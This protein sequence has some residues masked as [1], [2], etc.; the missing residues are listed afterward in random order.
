LSEVPNEARTWST[1][2][3]SGIETFTAS[4]CGVLEFV[5]LGVVV[6]V[7]VAVSGVVVVVTVA[8]A[9]AGVAVVVT[10]AVA[11]S[12][13][14]VV[15]TV[16]VAVAVAVSGVVVVVTV[17]V[18]VAVSGVVVVVT[19]AGFKMAPDPVSHTRPSE[20]VATP[21]L[22]FVCTVAVSDVPLLISNSLPLYVTFSPCQPDTFPVGE[23]VVWKI[24]RLP[25]GHPIYS[26]GIFPPFPN[27]SALVATITPHTLPLG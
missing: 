2:T 27:G 4:V 6:V 15:V 26:T 16:A 19:V 8:V 1:A 7:T 11:V 18:A 21:P 23:A 20:S 24:I 17:A 10:V 12:G 5:G 3:E 9:G 22:I 25:T 14:V 13:V